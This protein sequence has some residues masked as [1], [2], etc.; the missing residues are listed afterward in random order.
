MK[1]ERESPTR[2]GHNAMSGDRFMAF[3]GHKPTKVTNRI[4]PSSDSHYRARKT[5][6]R[7]PSEPA[8]FEVT[9]LPPDVSAR[10]RAK[11]RETQK[12]IGVVSGRLRASRR[13]CR[14][15]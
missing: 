8:H 7:M 3:L 13:Q 9:H 1:R 6:V 11:Q 4:D 15:A 5:S 14:A 12:R 10:Q 2:P